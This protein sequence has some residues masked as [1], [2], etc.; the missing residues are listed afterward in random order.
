MLAPGRRRR[1][2]GPSGERPGA[3]IEGGDQQ[4]PLGPFGESDERAD[5]LDMHLRVAGVRAQ[6]QFPDPLEYELAI[7]VD[8]A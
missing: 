2:A 4:L 1:R 3:D 7:V 5:A 6:R 8:G